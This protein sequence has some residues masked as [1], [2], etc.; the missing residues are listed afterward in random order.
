MKYYL[1]QV[2]AT[3]FDFLYRLKVACLKEYITAIWGWDDE[4]QR[5]H[6]AAHFDPAGSQIVVAYGRDAGQ[7]S[8][9]ERPE[10]RYLSGIYLLPAYQGQGLGSQ[11]V[12]DV[13]ANARK[14]NRPVS[15]QVLRGNPARRLYERL[16]FKAIER[17]ATHVIMRSDRP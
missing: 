9:I 12:G 11:I 3:D 13:L 1:R 5:S 7:V 8:I 2:K 16:G 4:F 17:T 14:S 6:F 10:E 15:L